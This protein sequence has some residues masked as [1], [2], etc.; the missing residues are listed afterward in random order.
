MALTHAIIQNDHHTEVK[1]E[2]PGVDPSTIEVG[3]ENNLL[4]VR[5][6]RGELIL[7]IN[8]AIDVSKIKADILWGMLTLSV[9]LPELPEA[10]T[11]KVSI[12]DTAPVKKAEAKPTPKPVEKV[13]DL[14]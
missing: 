9:P 14:P 2:V 12:H 10:R 3:F 1:I 5:C 13:N 11:I 8:P 6:D 7:P 4:Q